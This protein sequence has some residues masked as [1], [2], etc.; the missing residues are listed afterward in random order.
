MGF[1]EDHGVVFGQDA[2]F[3]V[4]VLDGEVGEEEVVIDDDDVAFG[5]PLVHER[6]EAALVIGALLAGAEVAAGVH[7]GPRGA[8]FRQGFDFGA[9]AE[10]G[11]LFPLADDL[12]IGYF[13][14][15]GQHRPLYR[16][17]K[18]SGGR[19]SYCGPS[20]NRL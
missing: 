8:A 18:S 14:E 5:G 6:D 12:E 3:V 17:R 15:A 1:V 4:F 20:C 19:R 9:V 10:F 11:G 13:F 2:A 7:L 16:R